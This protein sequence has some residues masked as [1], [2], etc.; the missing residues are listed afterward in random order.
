M[1]QLTYV[2]YTSDHQMLLSPAYSPPE[3]FDYVGGLIGALSVSF[4]IIET[5]VAGGPV[6]I[7]VVHHHSRPEANTSGWEDVAELSILAET[8]P[9]ILGL[10]ERVG[11][12]KP[13]QEARLDFLGPGWYRTRIHARNRDV[14]HDLIV[15]SPVEDYLIEVW[16]APPAQAITLKVASAYGR[17]LQEPRQ[18]VMRYDTQPFPKP[19]TD[20]GPASTDSQGR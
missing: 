20:P 2:G 14:A 17:I 1:Q 8:Y 10:E 15:E 9:I 3:P 16:P 6:N 11:L 12:D 19:A 18:D 4:P 7:S 13:P 5:G